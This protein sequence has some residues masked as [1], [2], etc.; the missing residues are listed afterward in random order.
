[1]RAALALTATIAALGL[2]ACGTE[3]I[4]V[5]EDSPTY[6]GAVL[7]AER[8]S[9]CHTLKAAGAKGTGDGTLR[10]QG[11][12][13]DQRHV[14]ADDALL[15]IRNGGFSGAIMPQNIVVGEEAEAVAEFI[16]EHSGT[17]VFLPPRPGAP[18]VEVGEE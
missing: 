14:N 15:A 5:A 16:A 4:S 11:P 18:D 12:N 10:E 6:E 2:G 7:F 13:L 8:C 1:V 17:E 9:G 3:G